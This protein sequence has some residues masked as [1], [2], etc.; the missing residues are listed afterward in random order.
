MGV[1]VTSDMGLLTMAKRGKYGMGSVY[2][3]EGAAS[4]YIRFYDAQGNRQ[5]ETGFATEREAQD[6]LKVRLGQVVTG[7]APRAEEK[8]LRYGDLR[9]DLLHYMRLNKLKSLETLSNGDETVKGLTKLDEFFGFTSEDAGAKMADFSSKD[10]EK[11]FVSARRREGISDATII[12]S[13]KLL[14]KMLSLA[15]ENK[16]MTFAPKVFVPK[17]PEPKLDVL[18]KEQFDQLLDRKTGVAKQ[19][20]GVLTFLFY[21]G[22]RI[23]EG[24][25]VKW[26]QLDLDARKY[27]PDPKQNKTGDGTPKTLNVNVIES[28]G[29][30]GNRDEYVFAEAR[31]EGENVAK[32]FE[33]E[34]RDAML[35]LGFGKFAWECGQCH[36]VKDGKAPEAGAAAIECNSTTC[37]GQHIPMQWQYVGP[38]PHALRASCVVFYLEARIPEVEIMKITGH[39]SVKVFRGYARV[40][41]S[42]V[43]NSMDAAETMREKHMAEIEKAAKANRQKRPMLVVA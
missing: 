26:S 17:A 19:F 31:S 18:T 30:E 25:N 7:T 40:A 15:V 42:S 34:F 27:N 16:R 3:P 11:N 9:E 23:T 13:A 29:E 36:A 41:D 1:V 39:K 32:K 38:S 8:T 35:R 5:R 12:N 2:K 37:K 20:H 33:G 28:L 24:L 4:W 10:W 21:Q 22:T 14:R 43:M 6:A